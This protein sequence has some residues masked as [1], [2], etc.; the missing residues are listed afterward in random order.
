M[1]VH[2]AALARKIDQTGQMTQE[3]QESILDL[4]EKFLQDFTQEAR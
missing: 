3:D 4:A 2:A 1:E